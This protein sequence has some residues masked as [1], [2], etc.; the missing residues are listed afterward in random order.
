[1]NSSG[2]VKP[3]T[4]FTL[5][6]KASEFFGFKDL[7]VGKKIYT[8]S[9]GNFLSDFGKPVPESLIGMLI[10]KYDPMQGNFKDQYG[11]TVGASTVNKL[12]STLL[13][14]VT[15]NRWSQ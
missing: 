11:K 7:A 14:L 1:M 5:L 9:L 2:E 13:I 4:S 10:E 3:I 12:F 6:S 8:T 15:L